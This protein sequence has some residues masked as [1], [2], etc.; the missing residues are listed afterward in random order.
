MGS[1]PG[2]QGSK[3]TKAGRESS[4]THTWHRSLTLGLVFLWF[5]VFL[6][7]ID[8]WQAL[9]EWFVPTIMALGNLL[10]CSHL[11]KKN[12]F[13]QSLHKKGG[14]ECSIISLILT[15]LPP[16]IRWKLKQSVWNS[17]YLIWWQVGI[18]LESL[19]QIERVLELWDFKGT[20]H[21]LNLFLIL[22]NLFILVYQTSEPFGL[23]SL[24]LF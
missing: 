12:T 18:F 7:E 24:D 19:R 5:L 2:R 20:F 3:I 22:I 23:Q 10:A 13:Y 21:F 9:E 14:S 8:K 4:L 17:M 11:Q 16:L 1:A 6:I 15:A